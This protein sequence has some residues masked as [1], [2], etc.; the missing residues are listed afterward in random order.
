MIRRFLIFSTIACLLASPIAVYADVVIGNDFL[1]KN[2]NKAEQIGERHYGKEFVINSP[3]GYVIPKEEPGS[4]QGVSTAYSYKGTSPGG[5]DDKPYTFEGDFFIFKNGEIITITH[6]YLHKGKYW[7]VMSYSHT[8]QPPGWI[9]IDELLVTYDR[10]D[11][12]TL[13]KD[14]FYTYTGG[15]EAVLNAKKLVEW[16]WPGSDKEKRI[17]ESYIAERANVLYAYKDRDGREWGKAKYSERWICLRDP[18]NN[19]IPS[20]Y[21]ALQPTRWS[22]DGI[23]DWSA[24]TAIYPPADVVSADNTIYPPADVVSLVISGN[25]NMTLLII[26]LFVVLLAG[27]VVLIFILGKRNNRRERND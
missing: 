9:P 11:F 19:K 15:Y 18:E 20:F 17:V 1:Y 5:R 3:S 7:G 27:V 8:Y 14:Y 2:E 24:E 16:E 12:E 22:P 6:T 13:N 23:Y 25:I 26:S 4:E 10:Q 21:P